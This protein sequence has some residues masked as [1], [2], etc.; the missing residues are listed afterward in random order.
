MMSWVGTP[1]SQAPGELDRGRIW[2][3]AEVPGVPAS[4]HTAVIVMVLGA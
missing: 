4:S 1:E 3:V 2:W